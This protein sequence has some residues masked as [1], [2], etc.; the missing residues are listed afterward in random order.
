VL[1]LLAGSSICSSCESG[2]HSLAGSASCITLVAFVLPPVAAFIALLIVIHCVLKRRA[3]SERAKREADERAAK[4]RARR[5]ADERAAA[6]RA[7]REAEERASA[8]RARREALAKAIAPSGLCYPCPLLKAGA[9]VQDLLPAFDHPGSPAPDTYA[10]IDGRL[11]AGLHMNSRTGAITGVP[12]VS[13]AALVESTFRVRASNLK[14]STDCALTLQVETRAAPADLSYTPGPSL[15]VGVPVNLTPALRFGIPNTIFCALDLPRGLE[16]NAVTGII[17]GAA[18]D[19]VTECSFMV[20]ASNDYGRVSCRVNFAILNQEAPTGLRYANLSEDS[21]FIVGESYVYTPVF[22]IGRPESVFS[23]TPAA[24]Q[25]MTIDT[26]SGTISGVPL[27]PMPRGAYTVRMQNPKGKCEFR[28][29]T[30]VQLHIPPLSLKYAAFDPVNIHDQGGL[31]MILVCGELFQPAA[32][33]LKQGNHLAFKVDPPLPRGLDIHWSSGIITGR[34][35]APAKKTVYTVTAS[36]SK[37]S[38][39]TQILFATCLDYGQTPPNEWSVDQV[40]VW[41]QRGPNLEA[42]DRENL[43]SLNGQKLFSLRSQEALRREL[44]KLQPASHRLLLLEIENLDNAQRSASIPDCR[45]VQ[46]TRVPQDARRGDPVSKSVLPVELRGDY[47]P[48][49]VLGNGGFGIVVQGSRV[50][51]KHKQYYVA[52]KVFYSERPFAESDVKRM[53]REAALLGRIDSQH[54]VKLKGSGISD[55]ACIYWL[56]MDFLDG[57]N[58]Q[59]LIEAQRFFDEE[60]AC[61]MA[62]QVLLG[63]E[64]I[65]ALGVVHCDVKPANIMQCSGSSE[66]SVLYKL[67]DLGVAVATATSSASMAATMR[68]HKS[69]RGTPG[70][71][72]PEIIRNEAFCIGPQ[73][74]IWSLAATMFETLTGQLPFCTTV[75]PNKPSLFELMAA[76]VNLDEEP[77]DVASAALSPISAELGSIVRRGLWKR[78]EGRY[79][80]AGEMKAALKAHIVSRNQLPSNW[81]PGPGR[82]P[83]LVALDPLQAEC[84]EVTALFQ[85][86]LHP[87]YPATVLRVERVQ[88]PGQWALYQ[89]KKLEMEMRGAPGHGE[90]RLFHGTDEATVPK[91]VSTAFNRSYCGKNA[92]AFG[93]GVYFARDSSYSADDTYSRPNALGEKHMFLCRVLVGAY[94]LGDSGMRMPPALADGVFDTTVNDLNAPSIFVV[95]H[96][97]QVPPPSEDC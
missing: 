15:V 12:A 86:S 42:K 35:T 22:S 26:V 58:L 13:G 55:N 45:D 90:R 24:P 63:L 44:P 72:S 50:V 89:A 18:R 65:H 21:V 11:P 84:C 52:I 92:T 49:C 2:T 76:A 97:A 4:E 87:T 96:D 93:Q 14:G 79:A 6:E 57:K 32:P 91:I 17:S 39:Q 83:V 38:V 56:V 67:V 41:A 94:A 74:D 80:S 36:N 77:P 59:E 78:P 10:V 51:K 61:E 71:I 29:C 46:V 66:S 73:A 95:Y 7:R 48:V 34:P 68:D 31:Y 3:A 82:Q 1:L 64:A 54:V 28:F 70:Y 5:E 69:L 60:E 27:Q 20:T 23:M 33:D 75:A 47:E 40:Q 30:E 81:T 9:A 85:A 19:A 62:V 53:N 25:G 8:E 37:G 88:N 43:L 16:L